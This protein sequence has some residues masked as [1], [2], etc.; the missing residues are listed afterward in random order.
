M[1]AS[2]LSPDDFEALAPVVAGCER[3]DRCGFGT[4]GEAAAPY[5]PHTPFPGTD[6]RIRGGRGH[7]IRAPALQVRRM[8]P[9]VQ[10]PHRNRARVQQEGPARLVQ[11]HQPHEVRHALGGHSCELHA[12]HPTALEWRHRVF[13]VVNGYR[14]RIVLRNRVWTEETHI[15]DTDL[16]HGCGEAR[17]RGLSREKIRIAWRS[18]SMRTPSR[19]S[20]ATGSPRRSAWRTRC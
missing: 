10:L 18:T 14:D 15:N 20:V 11:L 12:L 1:L 17:M 13:E 6:F 2:S 8:R 16:S 9:R 19:R 4:F 5:R 3:C 7:R